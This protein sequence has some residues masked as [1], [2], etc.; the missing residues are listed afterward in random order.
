[1]TALRCPCPQEFAEG[2]RISCSVDFRLIRKDGNHAPAT[3]SNA[4]YSRDLTDSLIQA[5]RS[6]GRSSVQV[7]WFNDAA[8]A[9]VRPAAG[10]NDHFHVRFAG[11]R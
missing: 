11:T 7:I 3:I 9:G 2:A 8:I 6:F 4:A 10:H 5:F 1:M